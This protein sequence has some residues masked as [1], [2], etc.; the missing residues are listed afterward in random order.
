MGKTFK[1]TV[2]TFLENALNLGIFIHV[3]P[4][5]FVQ[6]HYNCGYVGHFELLNE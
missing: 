3:R 2:L 1:F 6:Q 5:Q 4:H